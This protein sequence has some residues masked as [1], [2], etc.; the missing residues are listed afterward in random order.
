MR[1]PRCSREMT[2]VTPNHKT[3]CSRVP[4][5]AE[6]L[7]EFR[8]ADI[9]YRELAHKYGVGRSFILDHLRHAGAS[10][11]ELR[12]HIATTYHNFKRCRRCD[13][14]MVSDN[15]EYP[16]GWSE[17]I[18]KDMGGLCPDCHNTTRRSA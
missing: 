12:S 2:V 16:A 1:C 14:F 10:V 5:P 6:L 17:R 3:T 13:I 18:N 8:S 4:P 7:E 9:P 15:D 11:K